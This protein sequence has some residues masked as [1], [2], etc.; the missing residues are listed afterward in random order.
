MNAI[1]RI[2]HSSGMTGLTDPGNTTD[3]PMAGNEK[4]N[5]WHLYWQTNYIDDPSGNNAWVA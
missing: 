1:G 4:S 3:N 5:S 2:S